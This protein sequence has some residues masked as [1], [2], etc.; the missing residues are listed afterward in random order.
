MNIQA[1]KVAATTLRD[2][3]DY[4]KLCD[5][6]ASILL[7]SLEGLL[8]R[9]EQGQITEMVEPRGIP[10][11]QLFTETNLQ[12]YGD[13]EKAYANF[14]IELAEVRETEAYKMLEAKMAKD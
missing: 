9:A 13:L 11:Y 8:Y 5:P 2:K 10:G 12:S 14:C 7:L 6:D 3:L 4:Y 1:L